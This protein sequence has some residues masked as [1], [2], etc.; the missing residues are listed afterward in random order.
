MV[1][2]FLF[3]FVNK[4]FSNNHKDFKTH[5]IINTYIFSQNHNISTLNIIYSGVANSYLDQ[6][7][8]VTDILEDWPTVPHTLLLK[9][10]KYV[11][12]LV[13]IVKEQFGYGSPV[14]F[15]SKFYLS[16]IVSL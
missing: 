15:G 11:M 8:G 5:R 2:I 7:D 12:A 16:S 14:R 6:M 10:H 4:L 13:M 1:N 3:L 9:L